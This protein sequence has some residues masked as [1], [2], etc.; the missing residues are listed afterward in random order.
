MQVFSNEIC[1]IFKNPFFEVHLRRQLFSQKGLI[2]GVWQEINF[3]VHW[4]VK[5]LSLVKLYSLW[6]DK[7]T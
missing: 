1:E 4:K 5:T 3:E 2:T 7:P 6:S